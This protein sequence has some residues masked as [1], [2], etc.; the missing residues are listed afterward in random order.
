AIAEHHAED[1]RNDAELK[2]VEMERGIGFAIFRGDNEEKALKVL[3][4]IHV[5]LRKQWGEKGRGL[6]P[7]TKENLFDEIRLGELSDYSPADIRAYFLDADWGR[8]L[9]DDEIGRIEEYFKKKRKGMRGRPGFLFLPS[10][11]RKKPTP[12][13]TPE[14]S[15]PPGKG[16][17][18]A[19]TQEELNQ[20]NDA[21]L[22][23]LSEVERVRKDEE[24]PAIKKMRKTQIA[25]SLGIQEAVEKEGAPAAEVIRRSKGGYKVTAEVPQYTPIN[26]TK[27]QWDA[28][29]RQ[30]YNVYTGAKY[31]FQQTAAMD[32]LDK[33]QEGRLITD[34]EAALL[35]P[36]MG[37]DV[38]EE[39]AATMEKLGDKYQRFWNLGRDLVLFWKMPFNFDVQFL[40]NAVNFVGRHPVKYGKGSY[41]ALRSFANK[42]YTNTLI[43]A[44]RKD[45]AFAEAEAYG[46]PFLELGQL[47][48]LGKVA[49]QFRGRL[50][51]RLSRV[52]KK[53]SKAFRRATAVVRF[54][55]KWQLAAER[56]FVASANY[57]M[58][59]LWK[60]RQKQ[61]DASHALLESEG[62]SQDERKRILEK[63]DREK[64]NYA[65]VVGNY[66]KIIQAKSSTGRAIQT[67]AN[68]L[69]WSP[70]TTWSRF[71]RPEMMLLKSGSRAYAM[72]LEA[73]SVAKIYLVGM[74][75]TTIANYFRDDDEQIE[76]EFDP[77]SSNWGKFKEGNTWFDFGAGEIQ[78][79]RAVAQ[80]AVA[81]VQEQ[82][83]V[84]A[85]KT[86]SGRR[87]EVP[88][89]E[90]VK[91]YLEGRETAL[92]GIFHEIFTGENMFGQKVWLPP[93]IEEIETFD[94]DAA[95]AYAAAWRR[96]EGIPPAERVLITGR[97]L[98]EHLMPA[99]LQSFV[100]AA[101]TDGWPQAVAAGLTFQNTEQPV[102]VG[103]Q[104]GF[105]VGGGKLHHFSF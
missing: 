5:I 90:L 85:I 95:D 70:S 25:K 88:P 18:R 28:Y 23:K 31:K 47:A 24:I 46:M 2:V 80:V 6:E 82:T 87:I 59:D 74:L 57:F 94:T 33:L 19:P 65:D 102:Q 35:I 98:S 17:Y 81:I 50:P 77:T 76:V 66:I 8:D 42:D 9:T 7:P 41:Q 54:I 1:A 97:W 36:V 84:G 69:L 34:A 100:E 12:P 68:F 4:E 78:H 96:I 15:P 30:V 38:V 37:I 60:T 93:D 48:P 40:R 45:P 73:T 51:Y 58:L 21:L 29:A 99:A 72:S 101:I 26:L 43:Q 27:K 39:I 11:R 91:N 44:T 3:E 20:T 32:A 75:L 64:K 53:R 10:F 92:I 61:W 55:G 14:P 83:G 52:G 16:P 105:Y 67:A 89:I 86:Q 49:E 103:G 62:L 71:R 79:Y 104:D 63:V 56:S 22:A 13:P